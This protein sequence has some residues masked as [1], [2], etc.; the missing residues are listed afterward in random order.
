MVRCQDTDKR[1]R[2]TTVQFE[3]RY[4]RLRAISILTNHSVCNEGG[5]SGGRCRQSSM[6]EAILSSCR[7]GS[8]V[9][10]TLGGL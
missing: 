3:R 2:S 5:Q 1:L 8:T 10:D 7:V 6:E 4:D 9:K